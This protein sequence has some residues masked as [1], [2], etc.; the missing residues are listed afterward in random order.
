[1]RTALWGRLAC[2]YIFMRAA[3]YEGDSIP[4][5]LI[6]CTHMS[7]KLH[8]ECLK[9]VSRPQEVALRYIGMIA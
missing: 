8:I 4:L 2:K 1:M 3:A 6:L 7:I 5:A 9:N